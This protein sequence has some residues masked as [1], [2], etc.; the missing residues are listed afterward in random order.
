MP[1]DG[2]TIRFH[3]RLPLRIRLCWFL[4]DSLLAKLA[5]LVVGVG[6]FAGA[7]YGVLNVF[8]WE[9]PMT[10]RRARNAGGDSELSERERIDAIVIMLRDARR[11]IDTL[12][13]MRRHEDNAAIQA[14]AALAVLEREA[15]RHKQPA[16]PATPK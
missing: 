12:H 7:T 5:C 9:D 4:R 6:L 3:G 2:P 13:C 8:G 1:S 11:T 10:V 14:A 16:T 15:A